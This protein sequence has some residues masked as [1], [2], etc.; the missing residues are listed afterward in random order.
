MADEIPAVKRQER[1][2]LTNVSTGQSVSHTPHVSSAEERTPV[3][4]DYSYLLR[5]RGTESDDEVVDWN[6]EGW[7]N[8]VDEDKGVE[9]DEDECDSI[10]E[11]HFTRDNEDIAVDNGFGYDQLEEQALAIRQARQKDGRRRKVPEGTVVNIINES[12]ESFAE[13]WYPGK[14]SELTGIEKVQAFDPVHLWEEAEKHGRRDFLIE[15]YQSDIEYFEHRLDILAAEI[16][17]LQS[18]EKHIK[19]RCKNLEVHVQN[20]E[21]AKWF[22]SIYAIPPEDDEPDKESEIIDLGS[23]SES[24]QHEDDGEKLVDVEKVLTEPIETKEEHVQK[25]HGNIQEVLVEKEVFVRPE[26]S[27]HPDHTSKW[28]GNPPISKDTRSGAPPKNSVDM[29]FNNTTPGRAGLREARPIEFTR[30]TNLNSE[31]Q[32]VSSVE[33]TVPYKAPVPNRSN[34]VPMS[35][36]LRMP[37]GDRPEVASIFTISHWS[38]ADLVASKDRKRI[39]MKIFLQISSEERQMIRTRIQAVKKSNLIREINDYIDMLI[40]G[41]RRLLGVLP[42]DLPKVRI[43]TH[44]FLSWWFADDYIRR[45]PVNDKLLELTSDLNDDSEDLRTFYDWVYYILHKTFTEEAF[46]RAHEPSQEEVII[47]SDDDEEAPSTAPRSQRQSAIKPSGI[48]ILD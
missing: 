28:G 12:M 31:P 26:R 1:A 4:E 18:S 14:D 33:M 43:I 15:R 44:F 37:H 6:K 34:R 21:E 45:T 22:L 42:L 19:E 47:I 39:T 13:Q 11:A 40:R 2:A 9:E 8:S 27:Q 10:H 30:L 23:T 3:G 38:M 24:S 5:W 20:L 7:D 48:V 35:Q 25:S 17:K 46:R 29:A 36:V 41:E 32:I 16:C